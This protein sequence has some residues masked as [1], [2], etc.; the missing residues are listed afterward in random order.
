MPYKLKKL[1]N[2][3]QKFIEE[4]RAGYNFSIYDYI[5]DLSIRDLLEEKVEHLAEE[6]KNKY[7]YKLHKLDIAFKRLTN[8]IKTPL[9]LT[10]FTQTSSKKRTTQWWYYRIPKNLGSELKKDLEEAG[11]I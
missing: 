2:K 10:E 1:L 7:L 8:E 11:L 6:I 4:I 3:Y 9:I 5:N